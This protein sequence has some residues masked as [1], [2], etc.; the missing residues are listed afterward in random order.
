[1]SVLVYTGILYFYI[2]HCTE[3]CTVYMYSVHVRCTLLYAVQYTWPVFLNPPNFSKNELWQ[4]NESR[5]VIHRQMATVR[6]RD[7]ATEDH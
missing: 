4:T 1:M 3:H 5:P 6:G 7:I 2:L